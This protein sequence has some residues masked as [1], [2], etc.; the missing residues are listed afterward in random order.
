MKYLEQYLTQKKHSINDSCVII[1]PATTAV[2]Y[3]DLKSLH[4]PLS[5]RDSSGSPGLFFSEGLSSA[6]V[7]KSV[8]HLPKPFLSQEAQLFLH[9]CNRISLVLPSRSFAF[10]Q[11][12]LGTDQQLF[13]LAVYK[14]PWLFELSLC[15][16]STIDCCFK[17]LKY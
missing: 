3:G 16:F 8:L 7:P 9:P 10:L 2:I 13:W 6:A 1:S 5:I 14:K 4:L 11:L 15:L 12:V 17:K